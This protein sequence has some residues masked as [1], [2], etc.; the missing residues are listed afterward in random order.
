MFWDVC[1]NGKY[2]RTQKNGFQ[3]DVEQSVVFTQV[4]ILWCPR[5]RKLYGT[6]SLHQ[7]GI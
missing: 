5:A 1:E 6:E 2:R 3:E 7:P 4:S